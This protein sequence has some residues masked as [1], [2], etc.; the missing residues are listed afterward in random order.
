[1]E[2]TKVLIGNVGMEQYK[3]VGRGG[4]CTDRVRTVVR[5]GPLGLSDET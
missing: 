4:V 1:M 2:R 3:K 5:D